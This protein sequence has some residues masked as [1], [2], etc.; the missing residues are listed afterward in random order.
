[1]NSLVDAQKCPRKGYRAALANADLPSC[2]RQGALV[3]RREPVLL[4]KEMPELRAETK[5][6]DYLGSCFLH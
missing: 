6:D 1:M 2:V 5:C 4:L 3:W